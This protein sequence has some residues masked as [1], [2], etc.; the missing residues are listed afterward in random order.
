MSQIRNVK[1]AVRSRFVVAAV[2]SVA[3]ALV[4]GGVGWASIPDGNGVIHGCYTPAN[5]ATVL[6]VIDTAR[7][8]NCPN[9]YAELTWNQA[10]PPGPTGA[11][12]ATG[13]TGATGPQGS[14]GTPPQPDLS[15]VATLDWYGGAYSGG[16]YAFN[17][18]TGAA[19]DGTHIWVT[20][21][22]GNSVTEFDA[23]NG[24]FVRTLSGGSYGFDA[25]TGVA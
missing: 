25:P 15:R 1:T 19:Y 17:G 9:G 10:G 6:K 2:A 16:S 20:N 22:G 24:A 5:H 12:G 21:A 8:A 3:T 7:K 11:A 23:G 18:P 14:A 4:V 13:A